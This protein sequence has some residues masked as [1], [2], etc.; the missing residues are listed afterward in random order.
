MHTDFFAK[1]N[2]FPPNFLQAVYTA[3]GTYGVIHI[4]C[5]HKF[6]IYYHN[7]SLLILY[8]YMRL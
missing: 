3:M 7:H 8:M 6:D 4:L 1:K 5:M 2:I